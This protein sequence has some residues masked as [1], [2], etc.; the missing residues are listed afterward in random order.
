MSIISTMAGFIV[1]KAVGGAIR[2]DPGCADY[3]LPDLM[4]S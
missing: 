2:L 1:A 3:D 4:G